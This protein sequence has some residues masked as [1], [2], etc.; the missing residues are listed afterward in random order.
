MNP[1][2]KL[3]EEHRQ[4]EMELMELE[5]VIET[6]TINYPNL[7]HSFKKLCNLW[8]IHEEEEEK[9]FKIMKKE[10]VR[11]P[12][13]IMTWE[14]RDLKKHKQGIK[15]AINSGNE[16]KIRKSFE[17][18]L[19]IIISKIKNHIVKEDEILYTLFLDEFTPKELKEM[20][21]A[22]KH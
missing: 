2:E 5:T 7:I 14:H 11:I 17:K 8:N 15:D 18:D 13:K 19:K 10:N 12:V 21:Q 4:I 16:S 20:E 9:I 1:I 22:I 3:K 6:D